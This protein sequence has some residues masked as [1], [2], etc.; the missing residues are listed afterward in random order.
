MYLREKE[1]T[2]CSV[3]KYTPLVPVIDKEHLAECI[4]KYFEKKKKSSL[5]SIT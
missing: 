5:L 4:K 3:N 2:Q 1:T